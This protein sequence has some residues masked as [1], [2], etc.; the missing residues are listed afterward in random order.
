MPAMDMG[1]DNESSVPRK[2]DDWKRLYHG[3]SAVEREFGRWKQHYALA[4]LRVRSTER[5][6]LHAASIHGRL[7]LELA[8]ARAVPSA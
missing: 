1:Y 2:S 6:R 7:A 8:R 3:R 5:A 4:I